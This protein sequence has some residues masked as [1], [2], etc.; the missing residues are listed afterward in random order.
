MNNLLLI[1]ILVV[2]T[3][4]IHSLPLG[5][6]GNGKDGGIAKDKNST[7]QGQIHPESANRQAIP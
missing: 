7:L 1:A 2:F 5:Q 4:L 3:K 6:Q